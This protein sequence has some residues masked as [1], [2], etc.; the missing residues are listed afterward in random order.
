M[1]ALNQPHWESVPPILRQLIVHIGQREI[2]K[3]FYLA[4]GTSLALQLGHRLSV[5]L[6]FFSETDEMLAL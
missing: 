6:D 5:D 2:A 3:R 4:G 1:A